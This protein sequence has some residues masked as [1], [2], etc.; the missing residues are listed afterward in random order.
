MFERLPLKDIHL[1]D[2]VSWWPPGIGWWLL[3]PALVALVLLA[4]ALVGVLR[5]ARGRRRLRRQALAELARIERELEAGGDGA[6]AME[7]IS[8]LLRRV[9]ITIFPGSGVPGRAGRAWV[10]WLGR[11]G[12]ADID[13]GALAPLADAPYRAVLEASPRPAVA[14]AGRWIRHVT[15]HRR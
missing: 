1:P 14:A 10:D 11:T 8:I 12:P 3:L 2:P 13:A 9:A 15:G 7:R 6:R 5:R 4:R